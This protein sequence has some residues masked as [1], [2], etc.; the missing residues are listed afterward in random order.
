MPP[1]VPAS[2]HANKYLACIDPVIRNC[3]PGA[4]FYTAI[5][6]RLLYGVSEAFAISLSGRDVRVDILLKTSLTAAGTPVNNK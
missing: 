5:A 3:L 6:S 2:A 4:S 1:A